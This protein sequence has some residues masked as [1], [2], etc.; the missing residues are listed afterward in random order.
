MDTQFEKINK[1][2][3]SIKPQLQSDAIK[4]EELASA[5]TQSIWLILQKMPF[6]QN[7]YILVT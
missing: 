7:S 1:T 5:E 2:G 3:N 4:I 6:Y